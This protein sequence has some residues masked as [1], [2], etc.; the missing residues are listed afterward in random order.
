MQTHWRSRF[1]IGNK[2]L[3]SRSAVEVLIKPESA[4]ES[5]DYVYNRCVDCG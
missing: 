5:N 2:T 4:L 3:A 1:G